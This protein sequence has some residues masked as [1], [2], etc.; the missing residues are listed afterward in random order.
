MSQFSLKREICLDIFAC[1]WKEGSK[2]LLAADLLF[3]TGCPE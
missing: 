2:M 3:A 1:A